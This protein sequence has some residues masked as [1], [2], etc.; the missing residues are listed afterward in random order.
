MPTLAFQI[1]VSGRLFSWNLVLAPAETTILQSIGGVETN[2]GGDY[3]WVLRDSRARLAAAKD[4]T[5]VSSNDVRQKWSLAV[6]KRNGA[7][8]IQVSRDGGNA[9]LRAIVVEKTAVQLETPFELVS[10]DGKR[11]TM[12]FQFSGLCWVL[13]CME[14]ITPKDGQYYGQHDGRLSSPSSTSRSTHHRY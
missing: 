11:V 12:L 4:S 9:S 10:R 8:V 13:F 14:S 1:V 3:A 6:P 2:V 5:W 7:D